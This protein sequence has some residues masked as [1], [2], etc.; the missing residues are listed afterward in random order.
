MLGVGGGVCVGGWKGEAHHE[1]VRAE[2]EGGGKEG[3][4]EVEKE[5]GGV[6][7]GGGGSKRG[8]R[9]EGMKNVFFLMIRQ[10]PRSTLFPNTTLFRSPMYVYPCQ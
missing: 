5:E 7:E 3:R 6:R 4:G 9:E 8:G 2:V 1:T 10:P